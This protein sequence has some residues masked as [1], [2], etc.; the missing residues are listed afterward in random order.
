MAASPTPTRR[1]ADLL[2]PGGIEAFVVD[3]RKA[4]RPWR[5]IS[6]D[7]WEATD[8]DLDVTYETLRS[9]FPD[10]ERAVS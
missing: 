9:W 10:D 4:G 5:L 6:R 2:V 7:L 8:G 3:R 1:L